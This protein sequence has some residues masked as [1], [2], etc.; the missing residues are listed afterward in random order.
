LSVA[1]VLLA[2]LMTGTRSALVT[3][4]VLLPVQCVL[5]WRFWRLLGCLWERCPGVVLRTSWG[6]GV[7]F[8]S[9]RRPLR[10]WRCGCGRG[11]TLH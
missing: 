8:W 7:C 5:V 2:L 6:F 9:G 11:F 4:L 10:W 3:L 1:L